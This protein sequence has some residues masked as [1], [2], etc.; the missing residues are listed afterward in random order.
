MRMM[1]IDTR[2]RASKATVEDVVSTPWGHSIVRV[3]ILDIPTIYKGDIDG[4]ECWLGDDGYL[5]SM[6]QQKGESFGSPL[7][8]P[9][10]SF[11]NN[12]HPWHILQRLVRLIVEKP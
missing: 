9:A 7:S 2:V 8:V 3:D 5:Y 1:T 11:L 10:A 12:T 4:F 6:D